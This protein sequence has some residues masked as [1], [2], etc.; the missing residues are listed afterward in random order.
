MQISLLH[1]KLINKNHFSLKIIMILIF[2]TYLDV[3]KILNMFYIPF[4]YQVLNS[5]DLNKKHGL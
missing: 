2:D 5:N 4:V 3:V 1:S